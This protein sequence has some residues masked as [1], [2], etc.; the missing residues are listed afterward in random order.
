MQEDLFAFG[1]GYLCQTDRMFDMRM[2]PAVTH[3]S[4]QMYPVTLG[5][6]FIEY[7]VL[8]EG[9]ILECEGYL[10]KILIEHASAAYGHMSYFRVAH[11][12]LRQPHTQPVCRD[13]CMRHLLKKCVVGR[14]GGIFE[15]V[16]AAVGFAADTVS[17]DQKG[18]L[19]IFL[20]CL[21]LHC[22]DLKFIEIIVK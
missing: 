12:P 19:D 16:A 9:T 13:E 6:C 18:F 14:L 8:G 7:V 11:L 20:F 17:N 2:Y 4:Y 5:K 21:H 10:D 15:C 3:Q 22:P 1:F